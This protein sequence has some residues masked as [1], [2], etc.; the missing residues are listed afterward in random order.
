VSKASAAFLHVANIRRLSLESRG[1]ARKLNTWA[2]TCVFADAHGD[3]ADILTYY[4][5]N[6]RLHGLTAA[7]QG[8]ALV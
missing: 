7:A 6:E 4:E 8:A 2:Q 3:N 5:A 1:S